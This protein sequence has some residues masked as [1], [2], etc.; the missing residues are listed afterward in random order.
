MAFE[1]WSL[2]RQLVCSFVTVTFFVF[3]FS[4]HLFPFSFTF[5]YLFSILVIYF[6]CS[7]ICFVLY[8]GIGKWF[9]PLVSVQVWQVR[10][11]IASSLP[12]IR[13]LIF[14]AR[15]AEVSYAVLMITVLTAMAGLMNCGRG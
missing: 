4:L 5:F 10:S 8:S 3:I 1:L 9:L 11:E 12:G 2:M 7:I 6:Q 13:I 14:C 15:I